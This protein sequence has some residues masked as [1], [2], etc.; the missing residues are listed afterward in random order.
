MAY[1]LVPFKQSPSG[2]PVT[3]NPHLV[4]YVTKVDEK[5]AMIVF[6]ADH[7]LIV[8]GTVTG[9]SEHLRKSVS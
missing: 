1:D 8:D 4:R 5:T 3:V 9:V 2:E 7:S 6:D